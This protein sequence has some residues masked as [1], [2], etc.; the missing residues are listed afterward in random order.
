[1]T[2]F[3]YVSRKSVALAVRA[4]D[5]KRRW[6]DLNSSGDQ[7]RDSWSVRRRGDAVTLRRK[8]D[9]A[10]L[11]RIVARVVARVHAEGVGTDDAV[12][13]AVGAVIA[14]SSIQF[15]MYKR[16]LI[17]QR[18]RSVLQGNAIRMELRGLER[19]RE[20]GK[21]DGVYYRGGGQLKTGDPLGSYLEHA[22]FIGVAEYKELETSAP[23][24]LKYSL[25]LGGSG[26]SRR[27]IYLGDPDANFLA[28]INAASGG[29][30]V[31]VRIEADGTF[32]FQGNGQVCVMSCAS[33]YRFHGVGVLTL[34][35]AAHHAQEAAWLLADYGDAYLGLMGSG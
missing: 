2:C 22:T 28:L 12:A 20:P 27:K 16:K 4:S 17:A 11:R 26:S 7:L 24:I 19:R 5:G 8:C 15:S 31:N 9:A 32:T 33:Q 25:T 13:A 6:P 10:T 23:D 18:A 14:D 30:T 34:G 3:S 29:E 35:M 1:M 21:G